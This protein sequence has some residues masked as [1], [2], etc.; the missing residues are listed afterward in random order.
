MLEPGAPPSAREPRLWVLNLDAELELQSSGPYQTPQRVAQALA[1]WIERACRLLAPGDELLGAPS[2]R[3]TGSPERL[4]AAWCPTPSALARLAKA[5]ARLPPSPSVEVLRRVNQRRFYLGLGGG[6]PGARYF[7]EGEPLEA[8]LSARGPAPWLFKRA[9]GFAGRGQ[10]RIPHPPSADDRRWL[11]DSLRQ[12]GVLGEPW[13]EI[14]REL[15]LHGLLD[16]TGQLTLGRICLQRTDAHRAWLSS[17]PAHPGDVS[18]PHAQ[19]LY[20]TAARVGEALTC[21]GYFGPFG[22]DGYLWR[23]PDGTLALN[24]F[25]E[26]NARYTMG[27]AAGLGFAER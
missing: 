24:P 21:A 17:E 11:A 4:G 10:R 26:L 16:A 3:T 8:A 25:G 22:V 27:F 5:G 2:A 7:D 9:Y 18:E 6:A 14:E 12:G 15:C 1:P 20:D 23:T 13:L 19:A